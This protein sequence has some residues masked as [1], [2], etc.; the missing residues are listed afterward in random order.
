MLGVY[1]SA[2]IVLLAAFVLGRA[3]LHIVG[4][5]VHTWLGGVVG[6]AVL[7]IACPLL[8]RL[9][10]RGVTTAIL[11]GLVMVGAMLYL[12]RED[13]GGRLPERRGVGSAAA[14][15]PNE[16][17]T[18]TAPG[19]GHPQSTWAL[20]VLVALIVLVIAS[21]P[22]A[23]NERNG[24]LGEGIYT[25]DQAAQLYWTDWLQHGVGPE[26]NAVRFG[27]PTG[28]QSVAATVAEATN[29]SLLDSFNG[30]LLAI[31]VLTALTALGVMGALSPGRRV[32]AASLTAL[33]Y[34]AASFLAQSAFKE[35]AMA[36]LVLAF[37]VT[38]RDLAFMNRN[39]DYGGGAHPRR[40]L[41]VVLILLVVASVFV[42]SIPGLVWFALALP[43][44]LILEL[45]T[46]GLRAD[47]AAARGAMRR[48]RQAIIVGGLI[49]VA[50]V[51][52]SAS[53]LSGFVDKVGM[54]QASAGRLSSPVFP[55]EA[56]G[57]WPEGD[58]RIVRGEVSGAYPAV[59]LG[60]LAAAIAAFAAFR[61]RDWGLIA[62]GASTVIVYV[63]AR[64]FASIY[65][66]AKA[67]AVMA[68]LV[69]LAVMLALLAPNWAP[70]GSREAAVAED[71]DAQL[72]DDEDRLP[73]SRVTI[74]RYVFGG[75][76]AVAIA[77]ST[78]LALRAAPVGFDQ[79]G[80]ELEHLSGLIP[81]E[82]V[83]FFGVDRFSGYWLRGTLMKS[84]GGYVPAAVKARP[85]KTWDQG[86]AMD[87]DT[88][89]PPRLDEFDYAVTTRAGYQS[90]PPPNVK[91][92]ARTTSFILWKRTG[93]TPPLQIIDKNG[94]PG[95]VLVCPNGP[96][97]GLASHGG[98]ATVL[99]K[100][101]VRHPESWSPGAHFDA[102]ETAT[103]KMPLPRGRWDL[104]LQYDSQVPLV[105]SAGGRSFTLPPSLDGMYLSLQGQAS[106]WRAGTIRS[107]GGHETV[108]VSAEEPSDFQRVVG[109]R[110]QVW[111]GS[112][113][114]SRG[115]PAKAD[116]HATCDRFV[117][118]YVVKG[119]SPARQAANK[120]AE[121]SG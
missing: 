46:G 56:L 81:N 55:G 91:P 59:A 73:S 1:A 69:V 24:V 42:Y 58:F 65:V 77:A 109:V 96:G 10:G 30:L 37:A 87:F 5:S 54:V 48:H 93:P 53:Q 108:T 80:A 45:A 4:L 47:L 89:P 60:L 49:I 14:P 101:V 118:H 82:S 76:V 22:F 38:L 78:F 84:P 43:I 88:L 3:L 31:P 34:L 113:A 16:H 100:P 111:L 102:P 35:T 115:D 12:W 66:E 97:H 92:V 110:R 2:A 51:A 94:T 119:T 39:P 107:G 29:T 36:L 62:V 8:I 6:F 74:A 112:I 52:F 19:D 50:V 9:P 32:I 120:A 95:R 33:P 114:A 7:T 117:D 99:D 28:P 68:P 72:P 90:T 71:G 57:I 25:N 26:P 106:F 13:R 86:L 17:P 83:V 41:I 67:L 27:Y 20:G 44:W 105:V 103:V 63:G 23:F 64:L 116:L 75:I 18:L 85:S 15:T 11:L 79:R 40:A 104:S 98:S 21:L 121:S 70:D 61:R